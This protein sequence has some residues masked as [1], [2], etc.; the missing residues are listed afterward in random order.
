[1]D[2]LLHSKIIE[3]SGEREGASGIILEYLR[4]IDLVL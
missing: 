1:M 4:V 2:L 3:S